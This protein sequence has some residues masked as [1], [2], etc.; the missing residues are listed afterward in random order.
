[1]ITR[2]SEDQDKALSGFARGFNAMVR[3]VTYP[4]GIVTGS[5]AMDVGLRGNLYKNFIK[6]G[7]FTGKIIP[8]DSDNIKGQSD[9]LY[10]QVVYDTLAA[11]RVEGKTL[12]PL[13]QQFM[14][15][16]EHAHSPH[17]AAPKKFATIIDNSIFTETEKTL[18]AK[19]S[20]LINKSYR[21]EVRTFF[22]DIGIKGPLGYWRT[23]NRN[24]KV[25]SAVMGFTVAAITIGAMLAISDHRGL[26]PEKDTRATR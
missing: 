6:R 16:F 10:Q 14:E 20:K 15:Q 8:K 11:K 22:E 18:P 25:E 4:L 3:Y 26:L 19:L 12:S 2:M 5:L 9:Q 17:A 13:S 21:G 1:M 23:V 7:F 24:Q